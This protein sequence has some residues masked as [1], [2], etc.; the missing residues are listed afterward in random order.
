MLGQ[1]LE[2]EKEADETLSGL[3]E[4]INAAAQQTEAKTSKSERESPSDTKVTTG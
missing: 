3:A 2:E 4:R 1:S